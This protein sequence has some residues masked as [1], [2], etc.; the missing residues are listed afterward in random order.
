M[1]SF[2]GQPLTPQLAE[3]IF[4]GWLDDPS[5]ALGVPPGQHQPWSW[6]VFSGKNAAY[7][8]FPCQNQL[9][10]RGKARGSMW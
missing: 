10:Y 3:D 7:D 8:I 6:R 2:R 1:A 9:F 4:I 5:S